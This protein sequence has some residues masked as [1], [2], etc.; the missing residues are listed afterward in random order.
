MEPKDNNQGGHLIMNFKNGEEITCHRKVTEFPITDV[1]IKSVGSMDFHK[2]MK[3]LN[4]PNIEKVIYHPND[5]ISGVEFEENNDSPN[6]P[7]MP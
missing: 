1:T 7:D 5:W 6:Y 3:G 4:I 2:T